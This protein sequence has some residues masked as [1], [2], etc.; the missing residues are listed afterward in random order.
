MNTTTWTHPTTGEVRNYLDNNEIEKIALQV[1]R[2]TDNRL[3]N[4]DLGRIEA[5]KFWTDKSGALHIDNLSDRG[6]IYFIATALR[7]AIE[8]A[9]EADKPKPAR[10][11]NTSISG[12]NNNTASR[13]VR[14]VRNCPMCGHDVSLYADG[15]FYRHG[16]RGA[17]CEG[18]HQEATGEMFV[19]SSRNPSEYEDL[20]TAADDCDEWEAHDRAEMQEERA[21]ELD[22][23]KQ[24]P[25]DVSGFMMVE[26]TRQ[27]WKL[28]TTATLTD[29]EA[30]TLTFRAEPSQVTAG[31][32]VEVI[33]ADGTRI[34]DVATIT[35]QR[36]LWDLG[37]VVCTI[38]LM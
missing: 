17:E 28:S 21:A 4:A 23:E 7:K 13:T 37:R 22:A 3:S 18:S 10:T 11:R 26:K 31:E 36:S 30:K 14:T 33:D 32:F 20:S 25:R 12:P 9:I 16:P 19:T 27:G 8:E 24:A 2:D 29:D 5:A 34:G 1:G 38:D 15:T 6:K 35:Y